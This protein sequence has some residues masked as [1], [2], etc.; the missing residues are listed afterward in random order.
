MRIWVAL[1]RQGLAADRAPGS[2]LAR[3][4]GDVGV[5]QDLTVRVRPPILVAAVVSG[6]TVL[7]LALVDVAAAA[8]VGAV[9]AVVVGLVLLVHRRVDAGAARAESALRVAALQ[10]ATTVLDGLTD[11]RAHGL[12]GRVAGD[13]DALAARQ[14]RTA[15]TG[16]GPPRSA[17]AWSRSGPAWP[18]CS[19]PRS[20]PA[21]GCPV[22][23]SP[24]WR[25]HR[26]RSLSRWVGWWA[27]CSAGA[28]SPT[29]SSASTPS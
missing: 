10:Q 12:A 6:G 2:A 21:R 11:L 25:W 23:R 3:V 29:P 5:V 27:V 26:W 18:P 17:P 24:S 1:A 20:V 28:R 15:R 19:P 4:V 9:L 13:L 16:T 14:A 8:V 7:A 22:R